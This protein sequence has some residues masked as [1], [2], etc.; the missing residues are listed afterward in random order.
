M[1]AAGR[2]G[3]QLAIRETEPGVP[4]PCGRDA[5]GHT[6]PQGHLHVAH[7]EHAPLHPTATVTTST[8]TAGAATGA[9]VSEEPLM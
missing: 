4:R 2:V 3:A 1:G 8:T 6:F 5:P 9:L 7:L